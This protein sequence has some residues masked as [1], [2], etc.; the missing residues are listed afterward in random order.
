MFEQQ[1]WPDCQECGHVV[2]AHD[3][4]ECWTDGDNMEHPPSG[5]CPCPGYEQEKK[6]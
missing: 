2:E 3:A 4:D 5:A 6:A 1:E